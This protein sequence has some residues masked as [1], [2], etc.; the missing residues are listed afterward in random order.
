MD[1]PFRKGGW[2]VF[3]DHV[4]IRAGE[5]FSDFVCDCSDDELRNQRRSCPDLH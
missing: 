3:E 4:E 5:S 1:N 2:S